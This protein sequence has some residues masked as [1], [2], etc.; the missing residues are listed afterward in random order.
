MHDIIN[1]IYNSLSEQTEDRIFNTEATEEK[2]KHI[3]HQIPEADTEKINGLL[4]NL[5]DDYR[6]ISFRKGFET[7]FYLLSDVFA[8]KG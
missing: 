6:S 4:G 2:Y 3:L 5:I 7:A 8:N 1:L